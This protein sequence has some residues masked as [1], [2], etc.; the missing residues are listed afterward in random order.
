M[1]R[2]WEFMMGIE[3][4]HIN[5]SKE[6][7]ELSKASRNY[8]PSRSYPRLRSLI[9]IEAFLV[10]FSGLS[11][12]L[13]SFFPFLYSFGDVVFQFWSGFRFQT[14]FS[15]LDRSKIRGGEFKKN[16]VWTLAR[17]ARSNGHFIANHPA[18]YRRYQIQTNFIL[19][20]FRFLFLRKL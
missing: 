14:F 10:I 5:N 20:F 19:S 1:Y 17:V 8:C 9:G 15:Y 2:F 11:F 13:F 4:S 12:Y 18:E 16:G 6:T 3:K 7:V